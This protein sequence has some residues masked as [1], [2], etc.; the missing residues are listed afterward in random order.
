VKALEKLNLDKPSGYI[1]PQ[2]G[3]LKVDNLIV[4]KWFNRQQLEDLN[5]LDANI[6]DIN[7]PINELLA[8]L[9]EKMKD[10][11]PERLERLVFTTISKDTKLVTLLKKSTDYKC[12]FPN[13]GWRM[14]KKREGFYIEVA[15]IKPISQGVRSVLGNLI[16]LYPNYHK[17]YDLG[18]LKISEQTESRLVGVL[19][20]NNYVIEIHH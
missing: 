8:E 14:A 3:W 2:L 7:K 18:D 11:S 16:I 4:S 19:N 17:E 12:Q 5:T 15:H 20:G 9:N 10:V 1:F 6:S 13:C